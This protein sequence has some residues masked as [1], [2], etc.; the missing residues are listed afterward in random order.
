M[1]RQNYTCHIR[2]VYRWFVIIVVCKLFVIRNNLRRSSFLSFFFKPNVKYQNVNQNDNDKTKEAIIYYNLIIWRI[3]WIIVIIIIINYIDNR[4]GCVLVLFLP[5]TYC[6]ICTNILTY[7][8]Y[9]LY[10]IHS[11]FSL[12]LCRYCISDVPGP[13][14]GRR[15]VTTISRPLRTSPTHYSKPII[16]LLTAV[17]WYPNAQSTITFLFVIKNIPDMIIKQ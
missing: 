6:Y 10:V 2:N 15:F 5:I 11:I 8:L 12:P 3:R 7:I 13:H 9:V 14:E 16:I 4:V 1:Q 17:K